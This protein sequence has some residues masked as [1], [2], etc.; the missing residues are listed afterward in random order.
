MN[1]ALSGIPP[2]EEW[3]F[4]LVRFDRDP[5]MLWKEYGYSE[6][7]SSRRLLWPKGME[8]PKRN[9]NQLRYRPVSPDKPCEVV[10]IC[11]RQKALKERL[12]KLGYVDVTQAYDEWVVLQTPQVIKIDVPIPPTRLKTGGKPR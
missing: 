3:S 7:A 6:V 5:K 4:L 11:I 9:P 2:R 12:C 1:G 8:L 10:A